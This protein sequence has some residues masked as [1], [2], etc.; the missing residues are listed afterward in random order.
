MPS[1]KAVLNTAPTGFAFFGDE[2]ILK[3]N[4]KKT[5]QGNTWNMG[6]VWSFSSHKKW[7]IS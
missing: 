3:K 5:P 4:K 1:D 7:D 6:W 2:I